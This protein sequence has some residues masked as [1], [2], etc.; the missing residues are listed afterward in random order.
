MDRI[1]YDD[2][3]NIQRKVNIVDV[4]VKASTKLKVNS[5]VLKRVTMFNTLLNTLFKKDIAI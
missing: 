2:I 3:L 1:S 4:I 5:I